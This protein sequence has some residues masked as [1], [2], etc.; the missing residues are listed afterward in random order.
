MFSNTHTHI[1]CRCAFH[2]GTAELRPD[3]PSATAFILNVSNKNDS[4]PVIYIHGL[5]KKL[6][7]TDK[8]GC[9][10]R[11]CLLHNSAAP[12]SSQPVWA[13]GSRCAVCTDVSIS[14]QWRSMVHWQRSSCCSWT[15]H[16][17]LGG[18]GW[19]WFTACVCI[20]LLHSP[21]PPLLF[22]FSHPAAGWGL[23]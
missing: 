8:A 1:S 12:A 15:A 18:V 10:W 4:L 2:N 9:W 20:L 21:P 7:W 16:S 5:L 14:I 11:R 3:V 22:I 19:R 6:C 17:Q 23:C 13:S